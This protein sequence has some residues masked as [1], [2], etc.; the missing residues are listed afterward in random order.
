M[1]T[2]NDEKHAKRWLIWMGIIGVVGYAGYHWYWWYG[3]HYDSQIEAAR[4][5]DP[6]VVMQRCVDEWMRMQK[7]DDGF[8]LLGTFGAERDCAEMHGLYRQDGIWQ[9]KQEP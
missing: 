2:S 5:L 3:P 6:P 9:R 8:T 1:T 7:A 4:G